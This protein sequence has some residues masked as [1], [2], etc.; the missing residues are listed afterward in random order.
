MFSRILVPLD[1]SEYS[2]RILWQIKR[3]A[4]REDTSV[5]LL[6]VVVP[7]LE[8]WRERQGDRVDRSERH[9]TLR[10][11]EAK[12]HLEELA[13]GLQAEGIQA[14]ARVEHGHAADAIVRRAGEIDA[15]LV[16]I[17][18]HGRSGPSLWLRGSVTQRVLE[19][20]TVPVLCLNPRAEE[21]AA[22]GVLFKRI[23]VPL[24]GSSRSAQVIPLAQGFAKIHDS[25]LVLHAVGAPQGPTTRSTTGWS[26]TW[27]ACSSSSRAKAPTRECAPI[28]ATPPRRSSPRWRRSRSTWW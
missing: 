26:I 15:E 24:D 21:Q 20:C 27:S 2:S 13:A 23:L 25:E 4:M 14:S 16:A 12:R 11:N 8:S 17:A 28:S 5:E 18:T 22:E 19:H 9:P 1:G 6:T 3:L 10:L 7:I